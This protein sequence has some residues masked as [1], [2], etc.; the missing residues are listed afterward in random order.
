MKKNAFLLA[1]ALVLLLLPS[2]ASADATITI[3]N[4]DGP[5]EGFNDPTP[6][7]PVGGNPGTTLG[8]QRLNVFAEA[9]SIWGSK[10][11]SNAVI[12]V[13]AAFN[14]LPANVLGSASA[15]SAFVNFGGTP[16]TQFPGA[17]FTNTA[18]QVALANK[19][20]G[21]DLTPSPPATPF[22]GADINA[23]FSSNFA[24]Y[25]GF[26]N[27]EGTLV[28][29]LP[30]VLHEIGH[31][32]GFANFVNEVTG[33]NIAPGITDI[34]SHYTFDE[35]TNLHW[36]VMTDPQRAASA[37]N[38]FNVVWDG[39]QVTDA[40]PDVLGFGLPQ[41]VVN[42]PAAIVG[43]LPAGPAQF[44]PP[45][46]SPGVTGDVVLGNDGVAPTTDACTPLVG[47]P[48]GS[49]ALVDRGTC[50]FVI[51]VANAQAA[52]AIAVLVA[53]N[54]ADSPPAGL[55][56][57]DPTITIP[58]A[59]ITFAA[60]NAIKGQLP[61]SVV[62]ATLGINPNARAGWSDAGFIRLATFNPVLLGSSISHYDGTCAPNQLMEPAINVDLTSAVEP[63]VDLTLPLFRDIGWFPDADLDGVA[64]DGSDQC[65]D[66]IQDATVIIDGCDSGVPNPV[67]TSGCSITDL[68]MNCAAGASNHGQFMKCVDQTLNGLKK[69]GIITGA[70]KDAISACADA[71]DLP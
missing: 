56:G 8:Q 10:L 37:L 26:D 39:P 65:P 46:A 18:Y 63:P 44:G 27:N 33:A 40:V 9:A 6:A 11:D 2:A 29:L 67:L 50:T 71:A 51:K 35:T 70:Q 64:N 36:N 28:D 61:T 53:D 38:I 68:V 4:L 22:A 62:N 42:S 19:R 5:N 45:L 16:G 31:G 3:L 41:V 52:G 12:V 30:V 13:R 49:I 47:F 17:E 66:S 32:L 7:A 24:F 23:Q 15:V 20:A 58:S 59:R 57:V 54:V 55:G 25:F 21:T 60:G 1:A 34:Y 43:S 48:A 14:P 69:Q